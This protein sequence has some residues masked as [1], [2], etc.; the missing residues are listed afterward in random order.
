ML[1]DSLRNFEG[2]ML[3]VSH[4]RTFLRGLANRVLELAGE[5]HDRP[6]TFGGSYVEYVGRMGRGAP[7]G[8]GEL[9]AFPAGEQTGSLRP[10]LYRA[11]PSSVGKYRPGSSA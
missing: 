7:G 6:L 1:V 5:E 4:D 3:F 11:S 9:V 8:R 10:S 2:T